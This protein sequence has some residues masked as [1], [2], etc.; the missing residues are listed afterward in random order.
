MKV[1]KSILYAIIL[2]L[3]VNIS[4]YSDPLESESDQN[5]YRTLDEVKEE[6]KEARKI[7]DK[8]RMEEIKR[9]NLEKEQKEKENGNN[10][11]KDKNENIKEV[12][13]NAEKDDI[14][15]L[16]VRL[17]GSHT[18]KYL[19]SYDFVKRDENSEKT[20]SRELIND[21]KK[22][23]KK[24]SLKVRP[25]ENIN[26][27]FSDEPSKIQVFVW[28]EDI[29]YLSVKRGCIKVPDYDGKLVIAIDGKYKNGSIRYAIVL[30]IRR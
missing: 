19:C 23:L 21:Y 11:N 8:Q 7:Q 17:R 20:L 4:V 9:K 16:I 2:V 25:N 18:N 30:D 22:L 24:K 3:F 13:D 14:P 27:E 12:K 26:F 29:E 5:Q 28:N 1:V 10:I 6:L 15:Q